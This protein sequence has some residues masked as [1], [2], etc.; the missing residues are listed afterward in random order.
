MP[1]LGAVLE[2]GVAYY[3]G[4]IHHDRAAADEAEDHSNVDD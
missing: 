2:H 3:D 1:S 4:D